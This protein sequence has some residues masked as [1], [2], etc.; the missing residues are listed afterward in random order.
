M[1]DTLADIKQRLPP[2]SRCCAY[3]STHLV[4]VHSKML[5]KWQLS[6]LL[7]PLPAGVIVTT[8]VA[9][10]SQVGVAGVVDCFVFKGWGSTC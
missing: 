3:L 10:A 1:L 5:R 6:G 7:Q 2:R 9:A 4:S 8:S